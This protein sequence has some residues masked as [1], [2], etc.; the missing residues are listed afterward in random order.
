MKILWIVGFLLVCWGKILFPIVIGLCTY[1]EYI[2]Y[3]LPIFLNIDIKALVLRPSV[4]DKNHSSNQMACRQVIWLTS[5]CYI[6]N[7]CDMFPH[8]CP[9]LSLITFRNHKTSGCYSFIFDICHRVLVSI[10]SIVFLVLVLENL[11][12]P[13]DQNILLL[14]FSSNHPCVLHMVA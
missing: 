13:Y 12:C 5:L 1:D 7:L 9:E 6:Y 14:T 2:C 3:F 8:Y 11:V 10:N 4:L